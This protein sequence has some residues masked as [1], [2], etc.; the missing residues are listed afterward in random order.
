MY[1]Q[2]LV[3]I[4]ATRINEMVN[5]PLINEDNEQAFFELTINML[6]QIF[7]NTLDFEMAE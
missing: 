3:R 6:L 1:N 7:L 4:L 2:E 5:I